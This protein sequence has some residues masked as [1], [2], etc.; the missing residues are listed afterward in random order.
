MLLIGSS[1]CGSSDDASSNGGGGGVGQRGPLG[2]ADNIG[3]CVEGSASF[4]GKKSAGTCW[5]DD[6]CA[7]VGDC[8][9]DFT[10]ACATDCTAT[11][12]WLQKDAYKETAGRT[13]DAWPPHTTTSLDLSCAGVVVR[14]AF[15]ENHGT[16]PGAKDANGEVFLVEVAQKQV[17]GP[18]AEL[19]ALAD[20]YEACE[21][22]NEFL[23]LNGLGDPKVQQMFEHLKSYLLANLSCT[24]STSTQ[25][26]VDL[27]AKGDIPAALAVLPS[28]SWASGQDFSTGF[29]Q[30]LKDLLAAS[31]QELAS[32]HVCNNDAKLQAE[33]F[34]GYAKDKS[35]K[36]CDSGSN[37]CAGPAWFYAP[38]P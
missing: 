29:D 33:L 25:G 17:T 2:K 12:R 13:S 27:L 31:N 6:L 21:C 18:R 3:K 14:S 22:G 8:C 38:S 35:V 9:S 37:L 5:C 32:F 30:A 24:G 4:C 23:S 20:A 26:L 19:E 36:A 34:A 28:C 15:R 1:A 10:A 7:S 16:K 11:F